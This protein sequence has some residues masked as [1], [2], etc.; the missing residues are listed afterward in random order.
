MKA[1]Y[2]TIYIGIE[3]LQLNTRNSQTVN[4]EDLSLFNFFSAWQI[5]DTSKFKVLQSEYLVIQIKMT[6]TT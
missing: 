3:P 5:V 1:C 4:L 2:Q 6:S